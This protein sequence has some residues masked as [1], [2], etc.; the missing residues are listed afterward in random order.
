MARRIEVELTS[1]RE[2][3]RW[4]WRAAG[5]KQPR[6]ELDGSLLYEG[7]RIGDVVRAEA[8]FEIDGILVT[9]VLPPKERKRSEPERVE[10]IGPPRD[11][12]GVTSSLTGKPERTGPDRPRRADD[13]RG[14]GR[15]ERS[16]REEHGRGDES[17]RRDQGVRRPAGARTPRTEDRSARGPRPERRPRPEAPPPAPRPRRLNP[18][19]AH[20]QAVLASLP[21]EQRPIAEQALRGGLP[22]VRQAVEAQ[23]AQ[24]RQQGQ[25]EVNAQ[26]LLAIAE[27]LLP[28]LKAADWRDRAEAAVKMVDELSVRD[29]RAVVTGADAARD[30]E[31]RLLAGT[32]REA[33]ERR[34]QEQRDAWISDITTAL[35]DVRL[36]RALRLSGRPPDPATRIPAELALRLSD[37]AGAALAPDA[38]ADR[39]QVLLDAVV[40]SPVRRSVKPAGLPTDAPEDLLQVARQA[41]GKVPALAGLLGIAMPPPPGPPRPLRPAPGAT[42]PRRTS[43]G[44]ARGPIPPPPSPPTPPP[45][46]PPP[47]DSTAEGH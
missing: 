19:H 24:L 45:P 34:L 9:S 42:P 41:A 7:A 11:E 10:I 12:R 4:T 32:L 21:P 2:D 25:P 26:P 17:A 43:G 1:K 37:A 22:G 28:Q 30:D 47:A 13:A 6:G 38:P 18:G 33:L 39:W 16:G 14:P 44:R 36:V 15:R 3:G 31:G 35:G 23:N 29:L 27:Q 5:A 40:E 8:D 46:S 20:R